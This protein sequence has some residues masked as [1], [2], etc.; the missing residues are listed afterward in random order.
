MNP[1]L[2]IEKTLMEHIVIT[3]DDEYRQ[4]AFDWLAENGYRNV[5]W[6]QRK[7]PDGRFSLTEF[8]MSG[9]KEVEKE[10]KVKVDLLFVKIMRA[11]G[12]LIIPI[13]FAFCYFIYFEQYDLAIRLI[14]GVM[15]IILVVLAISNFIKRLN[16]YIKL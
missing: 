4:E 15:L 3:G 14:Y 8:S 2:K 11:F 13:I 5:N 12:V 6:G 10:K 16:Q 7:N 9:Q 1:N